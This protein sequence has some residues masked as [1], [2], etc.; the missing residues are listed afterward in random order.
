M[1]TLGDAYI[2]IIPKAPGISANV[3]NL[4]GGGE[5]GGAAEKAGASL[6]K[7]LIAG[8][9]S[10][11][12]GAAIG[13]TITS[14]V[15]SVAAVAEYGDHIDK[16]SQKLGISA[17]AYQEW[18]A[19]LQHSGASIDGLQTSLKTLQIAAENG[20][21]AFGKLGI[22]QQSIAKMSTEE[23]F[24]ATITALQDMEE[25]SE[26]TALASALLGRG[27]TELGALLNTSAADTEA[28]RQAV[29]DLGGVL[30]DEAVKNAA[31]YQDTLQD[32]QTAVTGAKNALLAELL[33]GVTE[34]MN[35]LTAAF[36][37]DA[38]G[39]IGMIK[40]GIDSV[41]S[42]ITE[43]LPDF[44]A[45]GE[46]ML[47]TLI[48]GVVNDLPKMADAAANAV[49]N[50]ADKLVEEGTLGNIIEAGGKLVVSLITGAA[51]SIPTLV[52]AAGGLVAK[53]V[54]GILEALPDIL[55][56]GISI[57]GSII[58][59]LAFGTLDLMVQ[60]G[61]LC[62][63]VWDAIINYDWLG[64]GANIVAG[65][66]QG[67]ENWT[68]NLVNSAKNL[69][70]S[71]LDS[72]SGYLGIASPSKV[73]ANE[74]GKWI[75]EGIA[76]GIDSNIAPLDRSVLG[77]AEGM[78]ADLRRYSAQGSAA[79]W[80]DSG[81]DRLADSIS[82]RPVVTR[83]VLEGE[84]RKIFRVVRTT[85]SGFERETGYNALAGGMA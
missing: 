62:E 22:T 33:P 1:A 30:S 75:P 31:A 4:L 53:I 69:G 26:R 47:A 74:V 65:I 70:K 25:G 82:A 14:A 83:V 48:T 76:V 44:L 12:I 24:A 16:M 7:K 8:I 28:M 17:Q 21:D 63:D 59:G 46:E 84:A 77:M 35:G 11:G 61:S 38:E 79:A 60:V 32:L 41:L 20:N 9:A 6:G 72:V 39:G 37:G 27:A 42:T 56:A 43:K 52:A 66:K 19:I 55:D 73:M 54:Q 58:D 15:E 50:F 10:I 13:K 85:N 2:N 67:F 64:L 68:Q 57:I 23:L 36:G 40:N 51:Q 71:I 78:T 45:R 49:L 5:A 18:D 29:H 80:T 34:V 3:E 81:L